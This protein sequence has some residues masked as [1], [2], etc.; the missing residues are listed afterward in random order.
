MSEEPGEDLADRL[1]A[2][3]QQQRADR[4][5]LGS[6]DADM[7]DLQERRRQDVR[8]FWSIRETQIEHGRRL[9]GIDGRL[10]GM[11]RRLEGI[12]GRLANTDRRLEG[13]DR[14][15]DGID[16]RLENMDGRLGGLDS[17]FADM[18]ATLAVIIDLLRRDAG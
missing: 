18:R 4:R 8:L 15:L 11:D 9:D 1:T 10:D 13:M 16:G 12:D 2:L 17:G 14:R 6:L 5:A 7:A 3:E